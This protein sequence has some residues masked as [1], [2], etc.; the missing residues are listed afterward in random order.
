MLSSNGIAQF[1]FIADFAAPPLVL[2]RLVTDFLEEAKSYF[3]QKITFSSMATHRLKI[4][5]SV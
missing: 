3:Q 5:F 2:L 1:F 4:K